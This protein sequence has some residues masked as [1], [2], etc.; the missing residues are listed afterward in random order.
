VTSHSGNIHN[1]YSS[2][3]IIRVIVLKRM[4][5]LECTAGIGEIRDEYNILV[6]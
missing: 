2:S 3:N 6:G 5:Q 4:R 1:L